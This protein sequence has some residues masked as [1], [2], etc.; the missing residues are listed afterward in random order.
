MSTRDRGTIPACFVDEALFELQRRGLDTGDLLRDA[1]LSPSVLETPDSRVSVESYGRLWRGVSAALDDEF[2]GMD[3]RS[4]KQ[5]SLSFLCHL[6]LHA[7]TLEEALERSVRFLRLSL[8]HFHART[9]IDGDMARVI[10]I[11]DQQRNVPIRAFAYGTYFLILHGVMCWSIGRRIPLTAAEFRCG[12]PRFGDTWRVHFTPNLSFGQARTSITFPAEFLHVATVQNEASLLVFLREAPTNL[13]VRYRNPD[14]ICASIRRR[15]R[16]QDPSDWPSFTRLAAD[17]SLSASTLRRRLAEEGQTYRLLR[18]ECRKS[19][20]IG[21][22]VNGTLTI[23]LIASQLGFA[24]VSA[25]HRAFKK[26]TGSR[27]GDFRRSAGQGAPLAYRG[28][29]PAP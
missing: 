10:L 22:L 5:G 13:L 11:E 18:D 12:E 8:D 28:L 16:Q 25:F 19:M 7:R 27:P 21:L 9:E 17:L 26:W 24:E 6:A 20:A 29:A 14:G 1:A 4:M 3:S 2:F 15:L 23:D